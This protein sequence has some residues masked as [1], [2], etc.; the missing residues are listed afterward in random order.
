METT[1]LH[2]RIGE[3]PSNGGLHIHN[4]TAD[5][6]GH[7][8]NS[9]WRGAGKEGARQ[10]GTHARSQAGSISG[11]CRATIESMGWTGLQGTQGACARRSSGLV[12]MRWLRQAVGAA[13]E[14]AQPLLA[15]PVAGREPR[16]GSRGL[17]LQAM[18]WASGC[19]V[20][21]HP[22][23]TVT[24]RRA[25]HVPCGP[26]AALPP[27][28]AS[29]AVLAVQAAWEAPK[30]AS[31]ATMTNRQHAILL[32]SVLQQAQA[33]AAAAV[34]DRRQSVGLRISVQHSP[35][36]MTEWAGLTRSRSQNS[37]PAVG[38]L[39]FGATPVAKFE[40]LAVY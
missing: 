21:V 26:L 23:L 20:S 2:K 6:G 1:H 8:D 39:P 38:R 3:R 22:A 33:A 12:I 14:Q 32:W 29:V 15:P 25:K 11:V 36:P 37:C 19:T 10:G 16:Q 24:A 7:R 31:N 17:G 18:A 34:D 4:K 30:A 35:T 28:S 9:A 40:R 27:T 5:A 13:L